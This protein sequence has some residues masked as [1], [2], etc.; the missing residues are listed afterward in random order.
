M[1]IY[2][3][4]KGEVPATYQSWDLNPVL[5]TIDG[6]EVALRRVKIK[7]YDS[8][9]DD[10]NQNLMEHIETPL[11]NWKV[12]FSSMSINVRYRV[13]QKNY[14]VNQMRIGKRK[15]DL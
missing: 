8:C 6:S 12:I 1:K 5:P 11:K 13:S 7:I 2:L 15:I 14:T 10:L 4:S 3:W 9:C